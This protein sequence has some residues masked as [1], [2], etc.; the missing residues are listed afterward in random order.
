MPKARY[1]ENI[2]TRVPKGTIK[3]IEKA[4]PAHQTVAEFCRNAIFDEIEIREKDA[5]SKD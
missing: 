4:K 2:M 1:E 5:K 3:R